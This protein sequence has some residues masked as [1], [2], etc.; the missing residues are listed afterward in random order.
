MVAFDLAKLE[1]ELW[2]HHIF[3]QIERMSRSPSYQ[4]GPE[5]ASPV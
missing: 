1:V 4:T 3:P 2:A 5:R